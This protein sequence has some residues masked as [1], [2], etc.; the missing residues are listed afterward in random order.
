MKIYF[1]SIAT[2]FSDWTSVVGLEADGFDHL[3][4]IGS[5]S[6][7]LHVSITT[8][9][10]NKNMFFNGKEAMMYASL[11]KEIRSLTSSDPTPW[12]LC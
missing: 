3:L 7:R 11:F 9:G 1:R 10:T 8:H 12:W 5:C 2:I 6:D 4:L